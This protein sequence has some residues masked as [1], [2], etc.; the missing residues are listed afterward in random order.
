MLSSKTKSV[1]FACPAVNI[2]IQFMPTPGDAQVAV[3][4]LSRALPVNRF[5]ET[6]KGFPVLIWTT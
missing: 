6:S 4:K 5:I 1:V 2:I 3:M